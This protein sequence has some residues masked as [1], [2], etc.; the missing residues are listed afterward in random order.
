[1]IRH[2][3][4]FSHLITVLLLFLLLQTSAEAID[5]NLLPK[6]GS[7]KKT[8]AEVQLDNKF[9]ADVVLAGGSKEVAF[10]QMIKRGWE[11]I[12]KFDPSTAMKRFN[13]AY[14]LIPD[15]Y[16]VDW[17]FGATLG[18]LKKFKESLKYF[19]AAESKKGDDARLLT[20]HGFAFV[21][22]GLSLMPKHEAAI[23]NF[24]EAEKLYQ[25][26]IELDSKLSLAY[27]RLAVLNYYKGDLA[28]SVELVEK[29][30]SLGGEGL[31][32]KF[33][34]DLNEASQ[35]YLKK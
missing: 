9:I 20:D 26:A 28:K 32:P 4:V 35:S 11:G 1:M 19:D 24:I 31:D 18:Q 25:K 13:Q 21:S 2:Q 3:K 7:Q 34:S 14:L 33:V 15:D 30:R 27:S 12:E 6:F 5:K 8:P 16:R 29:S 17:G 23:L 10:A 22:Y